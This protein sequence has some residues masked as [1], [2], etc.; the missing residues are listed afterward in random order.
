MKKL[1]LKTANYIFL[2]DLEESD[3]T[4]AVEIY[5][6]E[7]KLISNNWLAE[8][9]LFEIL[10]GDTDEEIVFISQEMEYNRIEILKEKEDEKN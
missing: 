3:E 6:L 10:C 9:F 7:T 1:H 8:G 2:V 5:D 4:T